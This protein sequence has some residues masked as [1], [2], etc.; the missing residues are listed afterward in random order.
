MAASREN[1]ERQLQLAKDAVSVRVQALQ[2]KGIASEKYD[3]DPAWRRLNAKYLQIHG[4]LKHVQAVQALE[5]EVQQRKAERLSQVAERKAAKKV[6]KATSEKA[7]EKAAKKPKDG[8][9]KDGAKGGGK[10]KK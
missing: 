8:A 3:D 7:P 1:T 2:A 6:K 9:G 10:S 5:V 4:R